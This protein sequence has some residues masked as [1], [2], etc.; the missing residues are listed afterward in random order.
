MSEKTPK[1]RIGQ[2]YH[3][4][5]TEFVYIETRIC[6]KC[7]QE[8][9]RTEYHKDSYDK[10]GLQAKCKQC[11][12]SRN[13]SYRKEHP[14]Y[15]KR[16]GKE[17]YKRVNNPARYAKHRD[18]FITRHREYNT[19]VWG[20]FTSLLYSAKKRAE[21]RGIPYDLDRE[22]LLSQYK[23][24]NGTC[25]LS[26]LELDFSFNAIKGRKFNPLSP[27]LDRIDSTKGYTKNNVRLICT[28]M[29]LALNNF[30]EDLF[31]KVI[32]GYMSKTYKDSTE[33][34]RRSSNKNRRRHQTD[35]EWSVSADGFDENEFDVIDF[36]KK[37]NNE[38]GK[39]D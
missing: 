26:G 21:K 23:N 31:K 33:R 3:K 32:A 20:R 5:P 19:S 2:I 6:Y 35:E 28:A 8:K 15:F 7:K 24:Q 38:H 39:D 12:S 34:V 1:P 22:W 14:D 29:N 11:I 17:N 36:T 18:K 30:G 25:K 4:K 10:F 16:K 13:K 37:D 9:H 27:S